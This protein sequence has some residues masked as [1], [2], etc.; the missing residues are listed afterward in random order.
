M[1]DIIRKGVILAAGSGKRLGYLSNL[2]PKT[3]FPVYDRPIF[4]HIIDQMEKLKIKEVYVIVNIHK[5]K[6]KEYY[7]NIKNALKA[8]IHF[9]EQKNLNGTANA[10][11]LT[12]RYIKNEPFLVFL[13]D[14]FVVTD[15]LKP[16]VNLFFKTN[17]IVTEAVIKES[18]KEILKQTCSA[19]LEEDGRISEIIEKPEKP[20]Y[21]IRGCGIYL[22]KP[23]VFNF[24]R[25]TKINP[26]RNV[27]D[28]TDTINDISKV[29]KAY[30]YLI[31]G[32][33]IN[34]NNSDELLKANNIIKKFKNKL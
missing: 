7:K 16:M 18:N 17:S 27:K 6:I 5:K 34:I 25:E 24:I 22:F 19:C 3:L 21:N 13:G 1:N 12:E 10:I 8:R 9:I 31:N 15:S 29:K 32:Y 26:V 33:Q 11:L 20:P 28:I 14:E 30:G 4:H 23:E 2:L